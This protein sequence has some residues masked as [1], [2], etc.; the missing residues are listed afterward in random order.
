MPT[1]YG[2][3]QMSYSPENPYFINFNVGQYFVGSN[4]SYY[5]NSTNLSGTSFFS[6]NIESNSEN[7]YCDNALVSALNK[8]NSYIL[9][10]GKGQA[11]NVGLYQ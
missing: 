1:I 7:P 6:K 4:I 5:I 3:Y 8:F 2:L 9:L 10:C 11:I